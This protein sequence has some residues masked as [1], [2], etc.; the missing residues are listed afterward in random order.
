MWQRGK[1]LTRKHGEYDAGRREIEVVPK[2]TV[3]ARV[4]NLGIEADKGLGES[5][6]YHLLIVI[7]YQLTEVQKGSL[8]LLFKGE[9]IE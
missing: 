9:T 4:E 5:V 7:D 3:T 1:G 8:I 6:R 2:G